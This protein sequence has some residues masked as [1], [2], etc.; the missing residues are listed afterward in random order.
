MRPISLSNF[1]NEIF[2]RISHERIKKVL[3][4]IISKE[5]SGFIQGRN[6]AEN[7]LVVQEIITDIR[8]RGKIPNMVIKMD[9][10]KDYDTVDWLFLSKVLRKVGFKN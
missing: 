8:K 9:M 3:P 4:E 5:Q 10:I 1:V 6:I 7:I 2:S